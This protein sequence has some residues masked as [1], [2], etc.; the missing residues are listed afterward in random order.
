M[1][2]P[3]TSPPASAPLVAHGRPSLWLRFAAMIY[4][5]VLLFGVVFIVSY[6]LLSAANWTY[7]LPTAQL[8]VLQG[9]LFVTVGAYFSWCW[10]RTGQT[11][12]MKS[13]GLRV[14]GADGRPPGL[15]RA[16]LRYLLAWHLFVP[17]IIVITVFQTHTL[18][19]LLVFFGGFC[20]MLFTAKLHP[21]GQ[22]LHD[23]LIGT[24]MVP[25]APR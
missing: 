14:V 18:V 21:D 16:V 3:P 8:W 10:S 17:G 15:G 4:E 7:P 22:L 25:V 23:R 19:D 24:R 2:T 11:L 5:L 13:W 6:A 9:V 20:V 1:V 12:A